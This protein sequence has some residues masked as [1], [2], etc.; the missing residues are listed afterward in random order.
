MV[1]SRSCLSRAL[2]EIGDPPVSSFVVGV[3]LD[4]GELG[5]KGPQYNTVWN[6]QDLPQGRMRVAWKPREWGGCIREAVSDS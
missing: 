5:R 2:C 4:R 3:S 1:W 6:T